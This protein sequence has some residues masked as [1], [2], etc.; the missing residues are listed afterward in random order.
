[1]VGPEAL[2]LAGRHH[3]D[4]VSPGVAGA[5]TVERDPLGSGMRRD[6]AVFGGVAPPPL[7]SGDGVG[8]EVAGHALSGTHQ[9]PDRL[10][11]ATGAVGDVAS[12]TQ[13]SAAQLRGAI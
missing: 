12:G 6:A 3:A 1:M 8:E 9:L 10:G 5:G 2:A 13:L 7:A 11:A 4:F